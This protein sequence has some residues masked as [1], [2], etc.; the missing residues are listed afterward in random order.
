MFYRKKW[1]QAQVAYLRKSNENQILKNRIDELNEIIA[2]IRI[3]ASDENLPEYQ[4]SRLF[5]TIN[6]IED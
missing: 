5:E 1:Q 2:D 6:Y 3:I 4:Y